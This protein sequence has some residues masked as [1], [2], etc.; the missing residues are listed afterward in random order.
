VLEMVEKNQLDRR[1]QL[2]ATTTP[3]GNTVSRL[4]QQD[5]LSASQPRTTPTMQGRPVTESTGTI[6]S[7]GNERLKQLVALQRLSLNIE[8]EGKDEPK[9]D[10][11][12]QL[13]SSLLTLELEKDLRLLPSQ[14]PIPL[15]ETLSQQK[16]LHTY[17]NDQPVIVE[18]KHYS[19][20][21]T[22]S[23]LSQLKRRVTLL[24]LQ[25]RQSSQTPDF[26]I[27]NCRGY[28]ENPER[29]RIGI[30][31]DY[32]NKKSTPISL[33]DRLIQDRS[34]NRL[35]GLGS[36]YAV[37]KALTMTFY[38]LHS[39]GW[40][41][42]SFWSDN[43]L[44]FEAPDQGATQ[45]S[46]PFVCGFDFSR[47][48]SPYELTENVPTVLLD[49]AIDRERRLYKHPDLDYRLPPEPDKVDRAEAV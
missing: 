33:L 46:T 18:W 47:P 30:L 15:G 42:K 7:D 44:F 16:R 27:L 25:L 24:T 20:R 35:R 22:A 3:F 12:D 34:E 11:N 39:V 48:D 19:T 31:F 23:I 4:N 40:L 26:S 43:V 6:K 2:L 29:R 28:F 49:Q 14:I 1:E 32:P 38:R 21:V 9:Q 41:H 37:A 17:C 36:R 5:V 13:H 10:E 8:N 45:L